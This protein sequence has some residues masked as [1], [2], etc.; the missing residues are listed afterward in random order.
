MLRFNWT[1]SLL[2]HIKLT[3]FFVE[4]NIISI[5]ITISIELSSFP[6]IKLLKFNFNMKNFRY[7]CSFWNVSS[8]L[9]FVFL[10]NNRIYY[11][12][13]FTLLF[14]I[15]EQP[16][17]SF[18]VFVHNSSISGHKNMKLRENVFYEMINWILHYCGFGKNL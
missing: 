4:M 2:I 15:K 12:C 17:L 11:E 18:F 14:K 9:L 8:K 3:F 7:F 6:R 5:M 16:V 1:R 10:L 13:Y